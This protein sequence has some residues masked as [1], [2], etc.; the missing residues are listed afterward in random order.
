MPMLS[1]MT[2]SKKPLSFIGESLETTPWSLAR[3]VG[4]LT[5]LRSSNSV[6]NNIFLDELVLLE[7]VEG[8]DDIVDEDGG[9]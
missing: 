1:P 4:S 2:A 8:W 5:D 7:A 9:D 3:L 6:L